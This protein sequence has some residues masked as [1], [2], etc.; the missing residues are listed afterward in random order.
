MMIRD[1]DGMDA[2]VQDYGD[3]I[4]AERRPLLDRL[5]RMILRGSPR[6]PRIEQRAGNLA[7]TKA[8]DEIDDDAELLGPFE[9][10]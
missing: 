9:R 7:R 6:R 4:P 2:A 10:C 1:D 3:A 5:N 8:M